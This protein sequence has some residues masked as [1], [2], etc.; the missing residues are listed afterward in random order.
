MVTKGALKNILEVCS[1]AEI[2]EGKV[3]D[4][5]EVSASVEKEFEEYSGKG[6][7]TLGVAYKR[8]SEKSTIEEEREEN[9]MS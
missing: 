2:G 8:I 9:M 6:L 3:V 1:S 5:A 7:R 4:I